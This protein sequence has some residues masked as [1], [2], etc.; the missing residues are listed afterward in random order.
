MTQNDFIEELKK[1]DVSLTQEML[2]KLE[3]YYEM[4]IE[5]NKVMNLTGITE[6]KEVYLKHFYDSLTLNRVINLKQVKTLCDLGSGA[7]FPGIVLKIVFPE[8]KITLVDS[9]NKRITFL[10]EVI[11]R[12]D[13]KSIDAVSSRIEEYSILHEEEYDVVTARAVAPLNVLLELGSNLIVVNG[14]FIAMKG[15]MEN[16]PSYINAMEKLNLIEKNKLV[17]NL[18]IENSTRT[19]IQIQK[20]SKTPKKFPRK[21][22]EI[23]KKPL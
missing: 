11:R 1:I 10:N 16:E 8:I 18:P 7:G 14:H 19:L 2:D 6:K 5:Y 22:S 4:L 21:Y 9:L 3:A 20:V 12:L 15:N 13:L 17:F 23:K